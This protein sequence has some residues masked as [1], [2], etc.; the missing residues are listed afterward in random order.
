MKKLKRILAL[1]LCL[2]ALLPLAACAEGDGAALQDFI[3]EHGSRERKMVA[4]TVDDCYYNR[5]ERIVEDVELCKN[6][7]CG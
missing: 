2:C 7:V 4:L 3:L 5:R 1:A 6:M